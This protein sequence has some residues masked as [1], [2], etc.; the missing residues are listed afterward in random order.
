[1]TTIPHS[2]SNSKRIAFGEVRRQ[3]EAASLS[4]Q[5]ELLAFFRSNTKLIRPEVDSDW[6]YDM[7][8]GYF[9]ACIASHLASDHENI[10]NEI[11]SPF[12][13]A[14]GLAGFFNW[15]AAREDDEWEIR[16]RIDLIEAA[17][18]AAYSKRQNIIETG[19][20]EH[21]LEYKANR[22]RFA[23]WNDDTA[24]AAAYTECLK[25]GE[26]HAKE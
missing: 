17:Y 26:A 20:L 12:D 6:L 9:L 7:H 19:F 24:L 15:Y 21:V 8:A 3:L 14:Y 16:N 10:D 2:W 13:A 23:H 4:G 25:W 22:L 18:K 1:M 5:K 11:D